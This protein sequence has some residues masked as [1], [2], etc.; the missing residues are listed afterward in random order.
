LHAVG[1][2]IGFQ[3]IDGSFL[4]DIETIG[5]RPPK[6]VDVVTF[7]DPPSGISQRDLLARNP[8]LFDHDKAKATYRVDAYLQSLVA[9]RDLLVRR[10]AYW[11]SIWSHRRT[12][13][14]KGFLE[15][16]LDP[17]N[18]AAAGALLSTPVATGG[19]P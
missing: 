14:W 12:L 10:T 15:V 16:P 9:R 7:Y 3:W 4:E 1:V 13:M 17:A 19:A 11:Y 6:D 18:D 5:A 8:D 2:S